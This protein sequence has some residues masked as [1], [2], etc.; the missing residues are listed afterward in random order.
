MTAAY[1]MCMEPPLLMK[2]R[3]L[4]FGPDSGGADLAAS[5]DFDFEAHPL[6]H[7][8]S[9]IKTKRVKELEFFKRH[10]YD[11][12]GEILQLKRRRT[13]FLP[14]EEIAQALKDDTLEKVR[15][16]RSLKKEVEYNKRMC[17]ALQTWI[18]T[19]KVPST[20]SVLDESWRQ[21]RVCGGDDATRR[22]GLTWLVQHMHRQTDTTFE[23]LDFP[24]DL[25]GDESEEDDPFVDVDVLETDT[26]VLETRV[27]HQFNV[28]FS[29]D[30]VSLALLSVDKTHE[31]E[32]KDAVLLT[33]VADDIAYFRRK[34]GPSPAHPIRQCVVRGRFCET[35]RTVLCL[36]SVLDDMHPLDDKCWT[37][38]TSTWIVATRVAAAR[39][40]VRVYS[41]TGHPCTAAGFVPADEV[42][43]AHGIDLKD[44]ES[45]VECLKDM[46]TTDHLDLR[47]RYAH[48]LNTVLAQSAI[49][50]V[51]GQDDVL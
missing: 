33:D 20:S 32:D 51:E 1:D 30:D 19:M 28:N 9:H 37:M 45:A 6:Y 38:H 3:K 40:R 17:D 12:Q 25:G 23:P 31:D 21:S 35:D 26:D 18:G 29:L 34:V 13:S 15:D 2:K 47:K 27:L 14:W 43:A 22:L 44:G 41:I 49:V 5:D 8:L 24:I 11:L 50:K 46:Y 39:T 4:D 16:N 10:I 48:H 42:A 36:K 7:A